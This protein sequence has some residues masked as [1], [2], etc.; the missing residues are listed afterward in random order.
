[1]GVAIG[2]EVAIGRLVGSRVGINLIVVVGVMVGISI[3]VG[4]G[5]NVGVRIGISV[6]VGVEIKVGVG[7]GVLK[8]TTSSFFSTT[9]KSRLLGS[10]FV[11]VGLGV[12]FLPNSTIPKI[13]AKMIPL[14]IIKFFL[15]NST[16]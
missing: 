12:G 15:L 10:C 11:T 4:V 16:N 3:G 2:R 7:V 13:K 14:T 8:T 6:G 5:V 9:L 1:V